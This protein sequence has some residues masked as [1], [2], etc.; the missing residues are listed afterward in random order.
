MKQPWFTVT[1]EGRIGCIVG[2]TVS[3]PFAVYFGIVSGTLGG[4]LGWSLASAPGTLIGVVLSIVLVGGGILVLSAF[5]GGAIGSVIQ[6]I[7][8]R[9]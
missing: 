9:S 5:V 2:A 4:G 8:K 6:R 1:R 7:F 3:L